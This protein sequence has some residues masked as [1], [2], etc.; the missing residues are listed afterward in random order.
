[1]KGSGKG[2]KAGRLTRALV[3]GASR[4]SEEDVQD[5]A[6]KAGEVERKLDGLPKPLFERIGDRIRLF[7]CAVEDYSS[8]RY[9]D[10]PWTT[11]AL[12]VFAI[13]YF[14]NP[15]DI[16]PD[17]IP[18]GGYIDDAGVI[19]AAFSMLMRDLDKYDKWKKRQEES[20]G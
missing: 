4:V 15:A 20:E 1:M 12:A 5:V 9:R 19:A 3:E 6:G 17:M 8:G 7:L 11:I 16:F 14:I 18:L 2:G 10:L 13:I